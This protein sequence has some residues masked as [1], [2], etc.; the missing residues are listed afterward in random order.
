M[1][2]L[3]TPG[4]Y[5]IYNG[6]FWLFV[7][8]SLNSGIQLA[9]GYVIA[10]AGIAFVAGLVFFL[11]Q[12]VGLYKMAKKADLKHRWMAFVPFVNLLYVGTLSG[13]VFFFGHRFK[14]AGVVTMIFQILLTIFYVLIS[15]AEIILFIYLFDHIQMT[16]TEMGSSVYTWVDLPNKP[17]PNDAITIKNLYNLS[18]YIVPV[19]SLVQSLFTLL[20]YVGLYRKYAP[21]RSAMFAIMSV[22]I[23][24]FA[25]IATFVMRNNAAID[26]EDY[27][28]ARREEYQRRQQQRYGQ[29]PYGQNGPYGQGGNP[30]GQNGPYGQ[31]PYGQGRSPYGQNPYGQNGPYGQN[32]YGQGGNPYG[33]NG[34]Y[35]Q[36]PYSQG[37]PP[38]GQNPYGQNEQSAGQTPPPE[39]P[40]AEFSGN[41]SS[42]NSGS[43]KTQT[44]DSSE[45]RTG[46]DDLFN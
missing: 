28:R 33:Q 16:T 9:Y 12:A 38:Y 21:R 17:M 43:G 34:P 6:L 1:L 31:N 44:A 19:L 42:A 45:K 25:E 41:E 24:F 35:G 30:Y 18:N 2:S 32:P 11:L 23:P 5:I 37:R 39:D 8:M 29:Y 13:E 3:Y 22:F 40:F 14:R 7:S 26:Y 4:W 15:L 20:L 27:M 10:F 36:N 46:E